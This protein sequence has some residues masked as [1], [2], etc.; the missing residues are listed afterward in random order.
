MSQPGD[1]P[2][3]KERWE[4]RY[5]GAEYVFG[6]EPNDFLRANIGLLPPGRVLCLAEGEGRNATFLAAEGYEVASIDLTEAG[7]AKTRRLAAERGVSVAA[8]V[9]D[10]ATADLGVDRWNA[11][12][13]IFAHLP[14]AVRREL[15]RRV[16]AA[17]APGGVF[18]LEAYTPSQI[19][20]GTGGPQTAELTMTLDALRQ[21]LAGLDIVVG[22]ELDRDVVEGP[23]HSGAGSV[24]QVIARKV[25]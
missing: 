10:L 18:L 19:G 2:T 13:S 20:R 25:S 22:Q 14:P 21:E 11:I 6:T 3:P 7:V 16:V 5:G 8:E 23:G 24:V 17:L 1:E 12:V 15:H 9:G 4:Q